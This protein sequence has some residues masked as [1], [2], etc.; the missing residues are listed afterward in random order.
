MPIK[1]PIKTPVPPLPQPPGVP[2]PIEDKDLAVGQQHAT[3][4]WAASVQL[5]LVY[6][7]QQALQ[8]ALANDVPRLTADGNCCAS[9]LPDSCNDG[10]FKEEVTD[11]F[12]YHAIN[13]K[14]VNGPLSKDQLKSQLDA[15][16]PVTVGLDWGHML[17]VHGRTTDNGHDR[18]FVYDPLGPADGTATYSQ[19]VNYGVGTNNWNVSWKEL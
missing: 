9:S 15:L 3:W 1:N 16:R 19:I 12:H 5:V 4:C 6:R 2:L 7:K 13:A 8:C 18:F 17:V 10:L 11:L 14:M